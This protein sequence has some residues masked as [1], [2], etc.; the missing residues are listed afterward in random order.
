MPARLVLSMINLGRIGLLFTLL[1]IGFGS[2]PALS[3]TPN[4]YRLEQNSD[5]YGRSIV[6]VG[7]TALRLHSPKYKLTLQVDAPSFVITG[8]N[9]NNHL[10]KRL[11][12]SEWR[13]DVVGNTLT[14]P[15]GGRYVKH[16]ETT[17]AGL[18][19]EEW[20]VYVPSIGPVN[21]RNKALMYKGKPYNVHYFTC[22]Q[23]KAPPKMF[24]FFSGALHMPGSLGF[25]LRM[26]QYSHDGRPYYTFDTTKVERV[27]APGKLEVPKNYVVASE[28]MQLMV[29]SVADDSLAESIFGDDDAPAED[30]KAGAPRR[31]WVP[32]MKW[33]K[34]ADNTPAMVT[35]PKRATSGW[36]PGR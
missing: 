31:G 35:V 2:M 30:A 29:G 12:N 21:R 20:W 34:I 4:G 28:L 22:R 3:A 9:D 15:E 16:G 19:A 1:A 5:F 6:C 8:M 33:S 14:D 7:D 25:P 18:P 17:I 10:Y 23:I 27:P 24:E 26:I 32:G 36:Y 13:R 11:T